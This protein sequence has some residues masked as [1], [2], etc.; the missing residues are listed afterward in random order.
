MG[1]GTIRFPPHDYSPL[2]NTLV[3]TEDAAFIH[4]DIKATSQPNANVS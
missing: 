2:W 1:C 3:N 4:V